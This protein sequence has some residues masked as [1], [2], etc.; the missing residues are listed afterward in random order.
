MNWYY[1]LAI[2]TKLLINFSV[3]I[4]LTLI[5]TAISLASLR[6][7][8]NVAHEVKHALNDRYG[9]VDTVHTHAYDVNIYMRRYINSMGIGNTDQILR[10]LVEVAQPFW[11]SVNA[12]PHGK[13]P[14][15][16]RRLQNHV[17]KY[18]NL[19]ENTLRPQVE[20]GKQADAVSTYQREAVP[21]I[22]DIFKELNYIRDGLFQEV[23]DAVDSSADSRP[24]IVVGVITLLVIVLSLFIATFTAG[25]ITRALEIVMES[26]RLMEKQDFS[27]KVELEYEDEIGKLGKTL[28]SL[29]KQQATVMR[30]LV[31]IANN[32]NSEMKTARESTDRLSHNANESENR[33]IAIAAAANQMVATTQE[34]A[35][36]CEVAAN[37]A[38][39]STDK[40]NEGMRTAKESIDAIVEQSEQSKTNNKQIEAMINQSRSINSIVNTIDEIAAQTNLLALNA[41]IEAARAGEAGRGFAVVADE[42]RALASRTSSSTGE[43][44]SKV[45]GMETVA[46]DA[47]VSMER[48]VTGMDNLAKNTT[49]LETVLN[50]ISNNVHSVNAQIDQIATAAEEQSTASNEISSNMQELTDAS[51]DV[52]MIANENM[53]VIRNTSD[54]VDNLMTIMNEFKF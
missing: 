11:E 41:A 8:Q 45:K 15:Q 7:N 17:A 14:D 47:T 24:L 12:L 40:T 51:R 23:N 48:A 5:I 30:R 52:A 29:R 25:Y 39:Q 18:R 9:L 28:E 27:K 26:M 13:Y 2:K 10:E 37:L 1:K 36:N 44:S 21:I 53:Q 6:A 33:T 46:N 34:I 19:F 54:E 20:A 3:L 35:A 49:G 38:R 16:V 31:E 50:E 4:F 43:I 22:E 42:V 32:I